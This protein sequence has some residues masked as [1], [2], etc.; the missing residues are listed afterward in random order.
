[1]QKQTRP[2]SDAPLAL[3]AAKCSRAARIR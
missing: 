2:L 3:S 1:V